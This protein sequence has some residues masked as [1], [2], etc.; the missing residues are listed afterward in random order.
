MKSHRRYCNKVK[1]YSGI[2]RYWIAENSQAI[3]EHIQ[4]IN[5]NKRARNIQTFDFSTLY[6]KIPLTDLKEKLKKV[7][8]S[9]GLQG[10]L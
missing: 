2:E 10:W 3:L 5:N 8:G 4:H 9:Q 1:F 6:T 7:V